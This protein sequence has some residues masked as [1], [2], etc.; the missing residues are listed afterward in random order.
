MNRRDFLRGVLAAAAVA[1]VARAA[2]PADVPD[3]KGEFGHYEGFK[4]YDSPKLTR[5]FV[6]QFDANL[7]LLHETDAKI[8]AATWRAVRGGPKPRLRWP[9][10]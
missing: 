9:R 1:P 3:F 8:K 7:R 6:E 5:E 4:F 10:R 2:M